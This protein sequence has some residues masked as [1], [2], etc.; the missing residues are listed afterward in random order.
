MSELEKL[1]EREIMLKDMIAIADNDMR[2]ASSAKDEEW[3]QFTLIEKRA[4]LKGLE[5]LQARL[6]VLKRNNR[7]TI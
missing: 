2:Y 5:T 7:L 3:Y 1:Q 6:A 4:M